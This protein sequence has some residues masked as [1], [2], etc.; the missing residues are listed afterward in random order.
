[1]AMK[2]PVLQRRYDR[3]RAR[4]QKL[5]EKARDLIKKFWQVGLD[6]RH[7]ITQK[8]NGLDEQ[9]RRIQEEATEVLRL[10]QK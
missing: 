3:L 1:M 4:H 8:L 7:A 5:S 10:L 6:R 9:R 2:T